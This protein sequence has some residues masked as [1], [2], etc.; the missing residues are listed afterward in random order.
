MNYSLN[1]EHSNLGK[2]C[3][4]LRGLHSSQYESY[5][6]QVDYRTCRIV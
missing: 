3:E 6:H 2:D 4:F 5:S 1:L